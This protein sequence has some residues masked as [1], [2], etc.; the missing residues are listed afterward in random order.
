MRLQRNG[1]PARLMAFFI[2]NPDEELTKRQ[3]A[4]K[5]NVSQASVSNALKAIAGTELESIHV[6]RLK[7]KGRFTLGDAN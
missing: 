1:L 2:A 7:T 6:V 4:D 3:I 5:F